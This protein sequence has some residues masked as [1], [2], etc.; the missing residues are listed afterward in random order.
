MVMPIRISHLN[1][2]RQIAQALARFGFGQFLGALDLDR[3]LPRNWKPFGQHTPHERTS[4]PEAFRALLEELGT[5]FIKVGQLL[6]TRGDLLPSEYRAELSKLQDSVTPMA[7]D[8]CYRCITGEM[9][10]PFEE[11]FSEFDPVPLAAASIGQAHAAKLVD[12]TEVVV[13]VRRPG[14][15]D[16]VKV[17]LEILRSLA[18]N[19]RRLG[20]AS[21]YDPVEIAREFTDALHEELDYFNERRNAM[22]VAENFADD[23]EVHIPRI[24]KEGATAEM[25]TMERLTGIKITDVDALDD[26]GI[27]RKALAQRATRI[28]F[29]M[30]FEDGY[31]HADPHPGNLFIEPDGRI[32]LIDFGLVGV[33]DSRSRDQLID[34]VLAVYSRDTDRL[35]D[36]L[37][38]LDVVRVAFD[39][40]AL[41]RDLTRLIAHSGGTVGEAV[42]REA[43]DIARRHR[44]VIPGHLSILIKTMLLIEGIGKELDPGFSMGT[45]TGPLANDLIELRYS[46]LRRRHQT[47]TAGLDTA[48]LT[49]AP[50][51][52]PA[53]PGRHGAW[54]AG[55]QPQARRAGARPEPVRAAGQSNRR[56]YRSGGLLERAGR[57]ARRLRPFRLGSVVCHSRGG[58][59]GPGS[60]PGRVPCLALP[61]VP[62]GLRPG[63]VP[64][65]QSC[66]YAPNAAQPTT[67]K[68]SFVLI[69]VRASNRRAVLPTRR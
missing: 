17:D 42:F 59:C 29:K 52:A 2:Y 47:A 65:A 16:Q 23:P 27:D 26:A 46:P 57:P 40:G 36:V 49:T 18:A 30:V 24:Y 62:A 5:T 68:L 3:F 8:M 28:V 44:L 60:C 21:Q 50:K 55:S 67:T 7:A 9:G 51:P 43:M 20:L 39:R 53:A 69:V 10:R 63:L 22:R 25:I 1:R 61:Q 15:V 33:L 6:S 14:A 56:S 4:R 58:F 32:G 19:A 37:Q 34:L 11:V 64:E 13:K 31:F 48:W 45:V 54:R 12:G 66:V 41:R 38:D 35:V